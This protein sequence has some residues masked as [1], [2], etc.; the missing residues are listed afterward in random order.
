M[1]IVNLVEN[2]AGRPGCLSE[3][4]LSFYIETNKHRLLVD[5]GA[6]GAFIK[7]A[8]ICGIDLKKIDLLIL[9]HGHYDHAGGILEF[10]AINPGADI[11]MQRKALGEY[12]HRTEEG[13][14][15]IGVDPK[16]SELPQLTLL[17]GDCRLDD[18]LALFAGVTGK[19]LWPEGNL[20]LKCRRGGSF[21]QDDFSHE[22]YLVV[23][24]G[25][26]HVLV[27][28]C[29]HNGILNILERYEALYDGAPS[30]VISG[31]HMRKK[32]GYLPQDVEVM[33]ET[34]RELKER[35]TV[36]YTGHCTGEY[37]FEVMKAI[38]GEKL[39]YVHSG[40]EIRLSFLEK[41]S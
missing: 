38:L 34:A 2:T 6:S 25:D 14:R 1:R 30:A 13:E 4:G 28:G 5:T 3:H 31:F 8:G 22:Q 21:V 11:Y 36:Y 32:G 7:N 37:P 40:D 9:S 35:D 15:Y 41:G 26:L 10:A 19:K 23:S 39:V 20:E 18:E 17:E 27:S 29:A 33:E 16:I 12:Y 24:E